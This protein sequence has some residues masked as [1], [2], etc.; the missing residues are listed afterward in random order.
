MGSIGRSD[1]ACLPCFMNKNDD[2]DVDATA[3]SFL[4]SKLELLQ[5]VVRAKNRMLFRRVAFV[6][7][8]LPV[9]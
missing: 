7:I 8:E 1:V 9:S 5:G 6:R 4:N 2:F 3:K